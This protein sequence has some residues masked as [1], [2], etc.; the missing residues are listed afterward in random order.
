LIEE[1]SMSVHLIFSNNSVRNT[2]ITCDSLGIHY[3]VTSKHGVV[4]IARWD[5]NINRNVT[6][7][8]FVL[9]FW[10]KDKIRL[11]DD[12]QWRPLKEVLYKR[13]GDFWTR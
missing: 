1:L 6:I 7:G 4:S 12:S 3:E 13:Q 8:Q 5:R 9:P 11:G 2:T 10:S